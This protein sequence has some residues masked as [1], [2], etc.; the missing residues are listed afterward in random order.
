M[1]AGDKEF[2]LRCGCCFQDGMV[3]MHDVL[4]AMYVYD[5]HKNDEYLR[6][7]IKPLEALLISHKKIFVKDS[8]VSSTTYSDWP[9]HSHGGVLCHGFCCNSD[10]I[11][12]V[13]MKIFFVKDSA[14]SN[15]DCIPVMYELSKQ[16]QVNMFH[17]KNNRT[18]SDKLGFRSYL[19][20]CVNN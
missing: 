7:V 10:C 12:V 9:S 14:K 2:T 11:P 13:P 8:A 15:S 16:P 4:D 3:T 20:T 1:V 19:L 6:R 5:N 17:V 18:V